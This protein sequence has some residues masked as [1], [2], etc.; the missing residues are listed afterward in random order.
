MGV[1]PHKILPIEGDD[2]GQLAGGAGCP[3]LLGVEVSGEAEH[4]D[5]EQ[6]ALGHATPPC[7]KPMV[8]SYRLASE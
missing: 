1:I 2:L 3:R 5:H 8:F 7:I 4:G 6:G